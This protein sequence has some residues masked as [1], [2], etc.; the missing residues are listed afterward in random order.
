MS[1]IPTEVRSKRLPPTARRTRPVAR[2]I[3]WILV[4]ITSVLIGAYALFLMASGFTLVPEEVAG[5]RFP[6][7]LGLRIHIV[8]SGIALLTGPF[9]FLRP[10]RRRFPV[11]HRTL[12]RIYVVACLVGGLAG[13]LIALFST[14]GLV[15][16]F[17]FLALA[18][19]WLTGT[20]RAWLAVRRHDYLTHQRWMIRS[21][22]LA[23]AAV[24]LRIY[25]PLSQ[26]AGFDYAASYAA[27]AWL[28]WVPNLLVAQLLVRSARGQADF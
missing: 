18:I 21:F 8:A 13:G 1:D 11:V 24:T 26:I 16:G 17:G 5:N 25:I 20:I 3:G 19:V 22:A 12:G 6:S 23:F 2:R 27:I 28:C 10:L 7:A 9:Q 4:A 14:G 15:A